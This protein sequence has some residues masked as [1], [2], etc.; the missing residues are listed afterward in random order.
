MVAGNP[1]SSRITGMASTKN[2]TE[3]TIIMKL[4]I[5]LPLVLAALA[6]QIHAEDKTVLKDQ[7]DKAGYSIGTD[8]GSGLRHD[9]VDVNLDALVAGLRDSF[10]GASAQLTPAQQQ[11]ALAALQ[12]EMTAK[13]TA[14]RSAAGEKA[15]KAGEE[16]L[17]ANKARTGVQ[18][19]PSGLQYKVLTEG[20]GEQPKPDSRVTV[21]YRGSLIDGT[22]FDSSYKRGEPTTFG[23]NQVIK[24]WG[25]ALPLMKTGSKW[26]IFI[27]AELAYGEEGVPGTIP[28]NSVLIFEVE[29]LGVKN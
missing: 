28:P 22:E 7:K 20:K 9:G 10:T 12:K 1:P 13:F 4:K 14:E 6:A 29:L 18:M 16:F 11:E 3:Q 23:V 8:I 25:E 5:I 21:N 27:P 15:K 19:L 2:Q 17:A 26:Q 24:G